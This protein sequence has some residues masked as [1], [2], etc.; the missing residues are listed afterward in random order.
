[1]QPDPTVCAA[2]S[3]RQRPA[4]GCPGSQTHAVMKDSHWH[5]GNQQHACDPAPCPPHAVVALG[6]GPPPPPPVAE[7]RPPSVH[8]TKIHRNQI[9]KSENVRALSGVGLSYAGVSSPRKPETCCN[10]KRR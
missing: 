1:M 10:N 3:A 6:R 4:T 5:N 2:A 8:N 7:H 9:Q